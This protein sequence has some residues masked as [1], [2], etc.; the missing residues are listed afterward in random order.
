VISK[1]KD[2]GG[3]VHWAWDLGKQGLDYREV[4]TRAAGA[5]TLGHALIEAEILGRPAELPT[6]EQ[7]EIALEEYEGALAQ[8][9]V[10]C[11]A[12]LEW[13]AASRLDVISTEVSLVHE[14]GR[15]GGT[16]DAIASLGG[17]LFL[18]DWKTSN[19]IYSDYIVQV[20]AYVE[21]WEH[22]R[23][24]YDDRVVPPRLA[25]RIEG[26]HLLRVGKDRGDYHHHSWPRAV[27]DDGL[28]LF[29]HFR[30]AYTLRQE[31]ERVV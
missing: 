13:A 8:A 25:E 12:Y 9:R 26:I 17:K 20:S 7:L 2:S 1:F 11:A 18:L 23:M 16:L 28:T 5:G 6:A 22:G 21:L 3:L 4:R 14:E 19:R 10:A 31:L 29:Q 27:L 30:Q 15:Y 24:L